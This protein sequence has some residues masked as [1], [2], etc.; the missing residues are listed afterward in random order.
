MLL[1]L[2]NEFNEK[3][4]AKYK[5]DNCIS[6]YTILRNKIDLNISVDMEKLKNVKLHYFF[7]CFKDINRLSL[8]IPFI[9]EKGKLLIN[10]F[11]PTLSSMRIVLK[12]R[13]KKAKKK[14]VILQKIIKE[15]LISKNIIKI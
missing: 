7:D 5:Q 8:D 1:N 2:N 14:E 4:F 9:T 12:T 13:K 3:I 6:N 15:I 11:N 10:E